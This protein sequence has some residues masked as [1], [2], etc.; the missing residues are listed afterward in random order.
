[1]VMLNA[2][3]LA[4]TGLSSV[5][6]FRRPPPVDANG[7]FLQPPPPPPTTGIPVRKVGKDEAT[8]CN[9]GYLQC[10]RSQ[11]KRLTQLRELER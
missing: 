4:T 2:K 11:S 8:F 6:T 3:T 7:K 5:R 9:V 10:K 1:M